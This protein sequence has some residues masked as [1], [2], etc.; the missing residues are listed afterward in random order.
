[1]V[2]QHVCE[3]AVRLAGRHP[4]DPSFVGQLVERVDQ[5]VVQRLR[6]EQ[7]LG[8]HMLERRLVI[9]RDRGVEARVGIGG[10]RG[11]SFDQTEPH[12][13]A[14]RLTRGRGDAHA[15]ERRLHCAADVGMAVDERAV[16]VEDREAGGSVRHA[17][18]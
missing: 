16:A 3:P 2:R 4:E 18:P 17:T 12:N 5:A 8:A 11:D 1:M 9:V 14:D 10:E 15:R 6:V 13:A 7:P